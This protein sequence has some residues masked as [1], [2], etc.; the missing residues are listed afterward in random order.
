MEHTLW[1]E[2]APENN[3]HIL[4]LSLLLQEAPG[5]GLIFTVSPLCFQEPQKEHC[6]NEERAA[7]VLRRR[8]NTQNDKAGHRDLLSHTKGE[9]KQMEKNKSCSKDTRNFLFIAI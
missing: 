6:W 3:P 7:G 2:P 8:M 4:S 1:G 9:I 5:A